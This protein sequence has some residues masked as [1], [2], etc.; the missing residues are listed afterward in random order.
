MS[1]TASVFVLVFAL[2]PAAPLSSAD[3]GNTNSAEPFSDAS[4][5]ATVERLE[6]STDQLKG[7]LSDL[8]GRSSWKGTTVENTVNVWMEFLEDEVDDA[9]KE[10]ANR[11]SD[12]FFEHLENSMIAAT[13]IN[14]LMLRQDFAKKAEKEWKMFRGDLNYVAARFHR[15]GLPNI[16]VASLEPKPEMMTRP[17]VGEVMKQLEADTDRFNENFDK[18]MNATSEDDPM[19]V[20]LFKSWA[21]A[22]EDVT[23]DLEKAYAS[24]AARDFAN[25]LQA[26]LMV[27]DAVNRFVLRSKLT[28]N[29]AADWKTVR[30]H[31]NVLARNFGRPI[32]SDSL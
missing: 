18:G 25:Q 30:A 23:D 11:N 24:K 19:R 5:K 22:I 29:T 28:E 3:D 32:L 27:G 14:R 8:I 2:C 17:D 15:P 7:Q 12:R 26:S 4:L 16:V 1:K 9:A 21:D 20:R 13:G 6:K 31:L 10:F